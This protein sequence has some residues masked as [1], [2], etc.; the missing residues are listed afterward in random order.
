MPCYNLGESIYQ[1]IQIANDYLAQH[2]TRFEIIVV[3]DGSQDN[4]HEE[5]SRAAQDFGIRVVSYPEN[6][7]KGY[8]VRQGVSQAQY[9]IIGFLDADLAIPVY[10]L[11]K[12]VES[13]E[14]GS[15]IAIASRLRPGGRVLI[16]V[17]QRRLFM[18]RV[19]RYL[20]I[21]IIGGA[22]VRDTQCGCKVFTAA[23][24]K[25][26]FPRMQIDRFAFDAELIFLALRAGYSIKEIPVTLQNPT[27]SSIRLIKDSLIMLG[28]LFRIRSMHFR[29]Y[30]K[31]D[32]L[33]RIL[34]HPNSRVAFDDFGMNKAVNARIL[35]CIQGL[36]H[37]R[38]AVM[39]NGVLSDQDK[40]ALLQ[41]SATLD[42]HLDRHEQAF[43]STSQSLVVRV[44][45]FLKQNLGTKHIDREQEWTAQ[46]EFFRA[47]FGRLPQAVNT[48]E[49]VHFFPQYWESLLRVAQR[50][51]IKEIRFGTSLT[52]NHS[53][54]A[55]IL[56][57]LRLWNMRAFLQSGLAT[58][59]YLISW[60]WLQGSETILEK[61]VEQGTVEIIMHVE[62]DEEYA[63]FQNMIR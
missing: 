10:E 11:V 33:V 18:E 45:S 49:H 8:A 40:E 28:D 32:V 63:V 38:V 3:N 54:V 1:N 19:F 29:R 46:I 21:A 57:T 42:I 2:C 48:H 35:E 58:S 51:G 13:I 26:I 61:Y 15:D 50:F 34:T 60:D 4:S 37:A 44:G 52:G 53:G 22:Q 43:V 55:F 30:M 59:R 24:K 25:D 16:P 7:G 9:E 39:M 56:N 31:Q 62:R 36:P 27:V 12:F 23:V 20:R 47:C 14:S 41:S 6:R 17:L 5:I